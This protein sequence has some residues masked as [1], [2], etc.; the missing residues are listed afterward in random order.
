MFD[1]SKIA[2]AV[3]SL[4]G[5]SAAGDG[6][7]GLMQHLAELGVDPQELQGLAPQEI[8]DVLSQHG[9]DVGN[10]DAN[11]LTELAGQLGASD[12]VASAGQWLSDRLLSHLR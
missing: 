9:I 5:D 7:T 3:G 2:D 10:I 4:S 6:L 11:Q 8:A 1:F 12:V